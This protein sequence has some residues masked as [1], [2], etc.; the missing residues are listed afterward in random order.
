LIGPIIGYNSF[1]VDDA[2]PYLLDNPRAARTT[3]LNDMLWIRI[4]DVRSALGARTY[5]TDDVLV[6][7][8]ADVDGGTRWK[9]DGSPMGATV[10]KVRSKPD[11]VTD[12]ASLGALYLGGVRASTLNAGQR[13]VAR[14]ADVLRRA[15]HFFA[16]DRM[17]HCATGF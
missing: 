2:L 14:N 6:V 7:E 9:V 5:G 13:L 4:D 11:V 8:L 1:A 10:Q 17:P 16:A 12:R 3:N 15:D